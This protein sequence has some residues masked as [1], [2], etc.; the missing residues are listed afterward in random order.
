MNQLDQLR[1]M[2]TVVADSGDIEAIKQHQPTDAT[3]N[4]SLILAAAQMPAYREMVKA[5]LQRCAS[6]EGRDNTAA[7]CDQLFVDF[8][9][10]I[11]QHIPGRISTEI[12]AT[13]SFDTDTCVSRAL[14]IIDRYQAAGIDSDRV[15]IK[16]ASTWEGIRAAEILED[17]GIHCNMTLLFS[18]NQAIACADAGA[19]LISPFVGRITDWYKTRDGVEHFEPEHDPGVQSVQRIYQYYKHFDYDTEVMAASFR[20]PEQVLALSGCDLLTIAP[21]LLQNLA[22]REGDLAQQLSIEAAQKAKVERWPPITQSQFLW[23][24]NED[25]MAHEKLAD[26]IRRFAQDQLSLEQFIHTLVKPI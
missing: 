2:T 13:L 22:A 14:S 18:L 11:L 6:A 24:L 5:S 4:P 23:H 26:G 3:T 7:L 19:T 21:N 25:A 9:V 10:E 20:T 15:L 16:L 12:D 17:K 8:G 1:T